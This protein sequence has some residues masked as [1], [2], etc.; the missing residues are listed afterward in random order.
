LVRKLG[1]QILEHALGKLESDDRPARFHF[2]DA[3]FRPNRK[4]TQTLHTRLGTVRYQ[5]WYFQTS[6]TWYAGFAPVDL[7]LGVV[8][9]RISPALAEAIG[10]LAAEMPKKAAIEQIAERFDVQISVDAY[11]KMVDEI[12]RTVHP[13]RDEQAAQRLAS[14]IVTVSDWVRSILARLRVKISCF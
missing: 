2:D 8:G 3:W 1:R 5:R 10:W 14:L 9:N 12:D 4:T 7:R 6:D 11:R 13:H